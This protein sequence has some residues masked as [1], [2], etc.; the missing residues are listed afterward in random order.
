[1]AGV[2]E[3]QHDIMFIRRYPVATWLM[4]RALM[5]D[6]LC[7]MADNLFSWHDVVLPLSVAALPM[8]S[9]SGLMAWGMKVSPLVPLLHG[10]VLWR[11]L[12]PDFVSVCFSVWC[13]SVSGGGCGGVWCQTPVV[14]GHVNV[15]C[16]SAEGVGHQ[17]AAHHLWL[18]A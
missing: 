2:C 10:C 11:C 13:L 7:L 14:S 6:D 9:G 1:M 18:L 16:G 12:V 4:A 15:V 17:E 3:Q 5:A 8:P